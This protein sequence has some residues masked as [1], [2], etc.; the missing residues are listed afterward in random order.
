[1]AS[2]WGTCFIV[3]FAWKHL[4]NL[5]SVHPLVVEFV[6][7][8]VLLRITCRWLLVRR[9]DS[10]THE[11]LLL[12]IFIKPRAPLLHPD[13]FFS[14]P[15][16]ESCRFDCQRLFMAVNLLLSVSIPTR[17]LLLRC[18]LWGLRNHYFELILTQIFIF[19]RYR[20]L[21]NLHVNRIFTLRFVEVLCI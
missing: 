1:M 20:S 10:L 12:D 9:R 19:S 6:G 13:L 17:I 21:W 16:S 2:N 14:I 5:G 11:S 15:V 7:R 4:I 18:R 8:N 3:T